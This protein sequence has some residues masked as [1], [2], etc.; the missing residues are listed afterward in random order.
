MK[1]KKGGEREREINPI[2]TLKF[3]IKY[4]ITWKCLRE[5]V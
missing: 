2:K 3:S 4:R 1:K 5:R